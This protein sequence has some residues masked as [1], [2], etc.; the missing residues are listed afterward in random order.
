MELLLYGEVS[1]MD[2]WV[3]SLAWVSWPPTSFLL[4]TWDPFN[5]LHCLVTCYPCGYVI[6]S[7]IVCF[8]YFLK[9]HMG[10]DLIN[11]S[12]K[13][14]GNIFI[15]NTDMSVRTCVCNAFLNMTSLSSII[16]FWRERRYVNIFIHNVHSKQNNPR[17]VCVPK[18]FICILLQ[19]L[20][21]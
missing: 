11:I 14:E 1:V 19:R 21:K 9:I 15:N 7:N 3:C 10:Q 12:W 17:I 5:V 16:T 4:L 18:R 8:H 13:F 6:F 20:N 2:S